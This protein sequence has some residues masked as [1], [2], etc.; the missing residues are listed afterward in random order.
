VRAGDALR[1]EAGWAGTE[2]GGAAWV[3][4]GG[5]W[6]RTQRFEWMRVPAGIRTTPARVVRIQS[7]VR[8]GEENGAGSQDK[9]ARQLGQRK[10]SST[11]SACACVLVGVRDGVVGKQAGRSCISGN[12]AGGVVR[13]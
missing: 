8:T 12:Y 5:Q 6:R 3:A 10:S 1:G 13:T 2:A 9:E 11:L 7:S 4:G